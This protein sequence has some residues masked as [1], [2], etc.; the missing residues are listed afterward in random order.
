M[1][2][3]TAQLDMRRAYLDG[4]PG[5]LASALAWAIAGAMALLDTPAHAVLALFA[6]GMFIFPVGVLLAKL[7]GRTGQHDKA[8]PLGS[9]AME[10]TVWMILCLPLTYAISL[11]HMGWFFPAMMLVIGG[12]YLTF[13]SLYGLRTYWIC[14]ATLVVAAYLIAAAKQPVFVGAFAGAAIE[15]GFAVFLWRQ[16]RRAP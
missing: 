6:G 9:L 16:A 14:G 3:Q 4:A 15:A 8:N 11:D 12:R 10:G 13:K 7:M 5:M 2:F 1:N